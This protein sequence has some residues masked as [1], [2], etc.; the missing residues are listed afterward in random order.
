[1]LAAPPLA[2]SDDESAVDGDLPAAEAVDRLLAARRGQLLVKRA[3]DIVLSAVLLVLAA[4]LLLVA[5]VA[6]RFNSPG[7][8]LFSQIRW[9]WRERHF[10]FYKLRTMRADAERLAPM[11]SPDG[12]LHK[13]TNDA[14]VTRVGRMLRRTSIDELPQLWNVLVG[15]MSL[16]GPRPLVIPMLTPFPALRRLRCKVRPGLTGLW[17]VSA[18]GEN[19]HVSAMTRWDMAYL[20]NVGLALDAVIIGRTIGAVASA[21]GAV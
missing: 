2:R 13:R 12:T 6:I 21:R 14:R 8:L 1:M 5:A 18:R 20:E 10:R 19:T 9:G 3:L 15:D 16:V 7:P 17:Q 11:A 4:P